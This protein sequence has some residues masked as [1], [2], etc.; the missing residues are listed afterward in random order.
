M[1]KFTRSKFAGR[2]V[3]HLTVADSILLRYFILYFR[4]YYR[5]KRIMHVRRWMVITLLTIILSIPRFAHYTPDSDKY[6]NL[7]QYF[8]GN[9]GQEQLLKP[10]AYR[11]AIPFLSTLLPVD[12]LGIS[13]ALINVA[14]TIAAY[15]VFIS[16][17][18]QLGM[19]PA[20]VNVGA[21]LL[22]FSFPTLNYASGVLTDPVGFLMFVLSIYLLLQD[23]YY[24]FAVVAC[25]GIL[26]RESLLAVVLVSAMDILI[27][28][29]YQSEEKPLWRK[30]WRRVILVSVPPTITFLLIQLYLFPGVPTIFEGGMSVSTFMLNMTG[31]MTAWLTLL[32]TLCPTL[33]L[34]FYGI[35]Q[36]GWGIIEKIPKRSKILLLSITIV[37]VVY[38]LYSVGVA[39]MSGRFIW[40]FYSVL[41]PVSV[42]SVQNTSLFVRWLE[43]ISYRVLG[44]YSK[45]TVSIMGEIK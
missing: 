44:G 45:P 15:L 4:T 31:R 27:R 24:L 33:L 14:A 41:V 1:S 3:A 9:T 29:F 12:D 37:S 42:L 43:P 11:V 28:F 23:K 34:F 20:Q 35:H 36:N 2:K 38:L 13:I 30:A 21:L 16:Y 10:F 6:V 26:V 7:A 5:K 8:R 25:L 39:Y 17:M 40:P 19:S 32:L 22:V 18:K